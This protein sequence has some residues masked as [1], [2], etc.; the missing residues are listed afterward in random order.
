MKCVCP[1][2]PLSTEDLTFRLPPYCQSALLPAFS[3]CAEYLNDT[4]QISP[5]QMGKDD[6]TSP[7]V[8]SSIGNDTL[9]MMIIDHVRDI[10]PKVVLLHGI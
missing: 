9:N 2:M 5:A 6:R 7:S 4:I 10:K 1:G 3:A 8:C